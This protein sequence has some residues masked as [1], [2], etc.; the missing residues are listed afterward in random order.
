MYIGIYDEDLL[1]EKTFH[2]SLDA[3]Q[4]SSYHKRNN[5][6]VELVLNQDD[7]LL[8][9]TKVYYVKNVN[10]K[11]FRSDLIIR[12]N[13]ECIGVGFTNEKK[14]L[15]PKFFE[16][17]ADKSLYEPYIDLYFEK[18]SNKNK[19]RMRRYRNNGHYRFN[20]YYDEKH[21]LMT[22][23]HPTENSIICYDLNPFEYEGAIEYF[24]RF[25]TVRFQH[26]IKTSD[27]KLAADWSNEDWFSNDNQIWFEGKL[28]PVD[29]NRYISMFK[30]N[31]KPII[32]SINVNWDDEYLKPLFCIWLNRI[33][34]AET[35]DTSFKL[36]KK[37]ET[38]KTVCG[39]MIN[40][41]ITWNN[42]QHFGKTFREFYHSS[43]SEKISE[44]FDKIC[45]TDYNI[46]E[47]VDI[48][49]VDYRTRRYWQ[50][51]EQIRT[52]FG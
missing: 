26:R 27:L 31:H 38:P 28:K 46:N 11:E 8:R 43:H 15:N 12:D 7:T 23:Q 48:C 36:K 3:M 9:F 10:N 44:K 37:D 41:L 4:I 20:F 14:K 49:I 30:T 17:P 40:T 13:V 21:R 50:S 47:M 35:R 22:K 25:K 33:L 51:V 1:T 29:F 6:I 18:T 19:A 42:D 52:D 39:S 16:Q 34:Y 5:D 45:E 32:F 2:Y 24:R